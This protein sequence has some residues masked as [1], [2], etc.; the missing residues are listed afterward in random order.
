MHAQRSLIFIRIII[1]RVLEARSREGGTGFFKLDKR[2]TWEIL[3]PD[4]WPYESVWLGVKGDRWSA[5]GRRGRIMIGQGWKKRERWAARLY[6]TA[7]RREWR[8]DRLYAPFHLLFLAPGT[9]KAI[10]AGILQGRAWFPASLYQCGIWIARS[11]YRIFKNYA[12]IF[13]ITYKG[14]VIWNDRME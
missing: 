11:F 8:R 13:L 12:S 6:E 14:E 10:Q 3:M 9:L 2:M 1:E 5:K 7:S 4:T